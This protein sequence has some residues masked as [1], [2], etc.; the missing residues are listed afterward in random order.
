MTANSPDA[1]RIGTVGR[2]LPGVSARIA[3]DGELLLRGPQVMTG[4]WQQPDAT[5]EL[6]H[7]GW[8]HTGDLAEIDAEGFV[9]ITG[10]K[11]EIIVTTS[12]KPVAPGALEDRLREH[13]LIANCL[14]VGDGQPFLAAMITLDPAQFTLWAG[15]HRKPT[16]LAGHTS[17]PDLLAE[18]QTAVDNANKAVS[19]AEAI[20]RFVILDK[21]WTEESGELTPSLKL[22]RNIVLRRHRRD[23]AALFDA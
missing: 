14:V 2:P 18:V 19:H 9:R 21:D 22:K 7:D 23:I 8:L 16:T 12:G 11:R 6:V 15:E 5:A 4:Y 3:D 17:D 10:R 20:R 1:N 13:P